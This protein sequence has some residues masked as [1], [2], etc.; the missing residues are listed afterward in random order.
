[1]LTDPAPAVV[2]AVADA[3][4]GKPGLVPVD[5]LWSLLAADQPAHVRRTAL[6]LLIARDAWTRI[7]ADLR[8]AG[9]SDDTLRAYGRANL[10]AWLDCE[11]AT[12]YQMPSASVRDRLRR[13]VDAAAPDIGASKARLLRWHLGD[14]G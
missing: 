11:A 4:L 1:M 2:R 12:T 8:V 6:R 13:L 5:R 3:M 9:D 14:L 10:N 7:E